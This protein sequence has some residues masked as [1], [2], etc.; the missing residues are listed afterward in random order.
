MVCVVGLSLL[1]GMFLRGRRELDR[2]VYAHPHLALAYLARAESRFRSFDRDGDGVHDF[3]SSLEQ[4]ERAGVITP[5]LASGELAGYRYRILR[6]DDRSWAAVAE[7]IA[8][9]SSSA[10]YYVDE[11]HVVRARLGAPADAG[12]EVYWSP[13]D[14]WSR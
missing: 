5:R 4:L 12:A 1:G 14:E 2:K 11:S 3:A 9:T 13:D 8:V 10:F 7:P 6:A